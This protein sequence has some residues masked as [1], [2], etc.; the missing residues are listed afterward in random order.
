MIEKPTNLSKIPLRTQFSLFLLAVFLASL[1]ALLIMISIAAAGTRISWLHFIIAGAILYGAF[2]LWRSFVRAR[3]CNA[4]DWWQAALTE[5]PK[6]FS[7]AWQPQSWR[8]LLPWRNSAAWAAFIRLPFGI[9]TAL[10]IAGLLYAAGT[11]HHEAGQTAIKN[12]F[13]GFAIFWVTM[14]VI[15]CIT[16]PLTQKAQSKAW[17]TSE[18]VGYSPALI[19]KGQGGGEIGIG[20]LDFMRIQ[21]RGVRFEVDGVRILAPRLYG[22]VPVSFR[23]PSLD[24]AIRGRIKAWAQENGIAVFGPVG[25]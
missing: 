17:F 12:G 9:F 6:G 5:V 13:L 15:M 20:S 7:I 25:D 11:V 22:F 19:G 23:V 1:A 10:P 24:P 18:T 3:V 4:A 16:V 8:D 21:T 14:I 2:A